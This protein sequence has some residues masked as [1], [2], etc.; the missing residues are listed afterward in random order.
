MKKLLLIVGIL[1]LLFGITGCTKKIEGTIF[2]V[3]YGNT[4]PQTNVSVGYR[5]N[6]TGEC[7]YRYFKESV[8]DGTTIVVPDD[9]LKGEKEYGMI[10]GVSF[11][12]LCFH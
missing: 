3:G 2:Q 9:Y 1:V 5:D 7:V 10:P 6:K 11:K 8:T 12:K 4:S